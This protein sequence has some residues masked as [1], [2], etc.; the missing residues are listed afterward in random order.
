MA[1]GFKILKILTVTLLILWPSLIGQ[2]QKPPNLVLYDLQP[3]HLGYAFAFNFSGYRVISNPG[4]PIKSIFQLE[5]CI[6]AVTNFRLNSIMNMVVMPGIRLGQGHLQIEDRIFHT[7]TSW[8][9]E[10]FCFELP[11]DVKWNFRRTRNFR[12]FLTTGINA[13]Y[14]NS[15]GISGP[16]NWRMGNNRIIKPFDFCIQIGA[17]SDFFRPKN[18][19]TAELKFSIGLLNKFSTSFEPYFNESLTLKSG[20]NQLFSRKVI[21]QFQI[22]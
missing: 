16:A 11:V 6:N 10:S 4:Y 12:G 15:G 18:K 17:G 8:T 19:L 14:E 21:L 3:F 13:E 5:V 22:D 7:L 2:N 20:L 9:I 1:K